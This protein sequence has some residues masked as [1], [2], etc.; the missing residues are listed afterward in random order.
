MV[1]QKTGN[2]IPVYAFFLQTACLK[3]SEI[4]YVI[5]III[6]IITILLNKNNNNNNEDEEDEDECML[7]LYIEMFILHKGKE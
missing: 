6:I 5:I 4:N 3:I 1:E 2:S 7:S